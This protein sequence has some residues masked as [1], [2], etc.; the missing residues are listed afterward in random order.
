MMKKIILF[1]VLMFGTVLYNFTGV[2][3]DEEVAPVT[4]DISISTGGQVENLKDNQ[5]STKVNV[6]SGTE[7]TVTSEETMDSIYVVWDTIP[8][9]WTMDIDGTTYTYGKNNFLHEYIKLPKKTNQFKI[10]ISGTDSVICDINGFSEGTLPAWVQDWSNPCDKADI[11][12]FSAHADDE[13]LFFGGLIAHYAGEVKANVQVVYLV[14]YWTGPYANPLRN[15]EA[16]NGLWTI[17][18][19][20]YPIVG[21]FEDYY[22]RERGTDKS[23]ALALSETQYDV[24]AVQKFI[25]EQLRRFKPQVAVGHDIINGE[26]GHGAH[27]L[28]AK[29]L[30]KALEVSNDTNYDPDTARIY[31][32]W[33]VPKTY[34]HLYNQN[35]IRL[36]LRVPLN[37]F[38]GRTALEMAQEGFNC[39]KTQLYIDVARV[40]DEYYLS[41]A[42]FGLYR[43]T[44]GEDVNKNDI[45]ENITLYKDMEPETQA[46]SEKESTEKLDISSGGNIYIYYIVGA[47]II[48]III[49]LIIRIN[50]NK[51]RRKRY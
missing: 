43:S 13:Q 21:E 9:N 32:L 47:V 38:G 41:C 36:D 46:T 3:A 6:S 22:S 26:Y 45:L 30:A 17:G 4:T 20:N 48:L 34:L 16:L 25:V 51:K 18:V 35:Q 37:A 24:E 49:I 5:Y 12:V 28:F 29:Y 7:I 39:H 33:D 44:V 31:G 2:K 1:A 23:P 40:D 42:D 27:M 14:Q 8:G 11:I 15:H 10:L 50:L 19:K